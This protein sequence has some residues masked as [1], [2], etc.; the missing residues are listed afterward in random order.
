MLTQGGKPCTWTRILLSLAAATV[1]AVAASVTWTA[2]IPAA[3]GQT[4]PWPTHT[5]TRPPTRIPTATRTPT[6]RPTWT[7]VPTSV[8]RTPLPTD[9]GTRTPGE[10]PTEPVISPTVGQ[11]TATLAIMESATP[12]EP[13]PGVAQATPTAVSTAPTRTPGPVALLF[14]VAAHPLFAG[15]GDE[16]RFTVQVAN[17]GYAPI[18]EVRIAAVLPSDLALH[19]ADCTIAHTAGQMTLELGSLPGGDQRILSV[20]VT[21][22]EDAWP[23][24]RLVT[25]WEITARDQPAQST[26]TIIELPWAELP[27]TGECPKCQ[28]STYQ[29]DSM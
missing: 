2:P 14:E 21:V 23:G 3:E 25:R 24:Q 12:S 28:Q 17:V 22:A 4:I 13:A 6:P 29:R 16:I 5:P 9:A 11:A 15:P 7:R 20:L 10:A 1:L 18:A 26:E 8:P 19:T 27:A